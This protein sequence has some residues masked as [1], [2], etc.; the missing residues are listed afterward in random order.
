[1]AQDNVNKG[2][3][4]VRL[5]IL[6]HKESKGEK[7][8]EMPKMPEL[9]VEEF[10][11]CFVCQGE[12]GKDA[13]SLSLHPSKVNSLKHH[14]ANCYYEFNIEFYLNSPRYELGADNTDE[15][16]GRPLDHLGKKLK[17]K[18]GEAACKKQS[19]TN[20]YGYKS[21]CIHIATEHGGLREI[22]HQDTRPE[23]KYILEK[24]DNKI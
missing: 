1:M 18:C 6:R 23:I 21:Y 5:A 13:K 12:T 2:V 17:Y 8:E 22:M 9:I 10:H 19:R 14:Y 4:E 11:T 3:E 24:L 7:V 20:Q 15:E 16:T